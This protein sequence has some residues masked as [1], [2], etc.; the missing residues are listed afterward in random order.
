M[1]RIYYDGRYVF[2]YH[3]L[4]AGQLTA[5]M[6]RHRVLAWQRKNMEDDIFHEVKPMNMYPWPGKLRMF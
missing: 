4:C 3:N 2:L 1:T 6:F 5:G